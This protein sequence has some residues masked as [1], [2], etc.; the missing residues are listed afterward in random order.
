[1]KKAT[2]IMSI[3]VAF[4]YKA[5][6]KPLYDGLLK[7]F[8]AYVYYKKYLQSITLKVKQGIEQIQHILASF[9]SHPLKEIVGIKV[10]SFEYNHT[11]E[12]T[13]VETITLP[14]SNFLKFY[15]A[16]GS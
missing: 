10:E 1:M 11:S 4:H 6:R 15:L 16:D 9:R 8:E 3:E 2:V 13:S 5:Q 7:L 12:K 14:K